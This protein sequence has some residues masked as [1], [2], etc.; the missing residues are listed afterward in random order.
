MTAT[1]TSEFYVLDRPTLTANQRLH[2][3]KKAKLTRH[4]R[5][6]GYKAG[7]KFGNGYEHV[8]VGLEWRVF[9]KHRRDV[10]NIVPTLKALCDGLVDA[11]V[12]P[13]DTPDYM[14][15]TMPEIRHVTDRAHVGLWLTIRDGRTA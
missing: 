3:A 5:T 7:S 4:T 12:V 9:T 14:T 15:K 1:A 10:D 13:D 2:W 11:G 8:T 6:I